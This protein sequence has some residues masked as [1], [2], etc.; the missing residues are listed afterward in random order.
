MGIRDWTLRPNPLESRLSPNDELKCSPDYSVTAP[1][2]N[3]LAQI[4]PFAQHI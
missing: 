4:L 1:I 3:H 2:V